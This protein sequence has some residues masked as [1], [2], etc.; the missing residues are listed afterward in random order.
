[1]QKVYFRLTCVTQ[2]Q[3]CSNSLQA[4]CSMTSF[5]YYYYQNPSGFCFLVQ[6][7]AFVIKTSMGLTNLNMEE[8]MK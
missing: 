5:Y 2:K 4:I 1:M 7:R 3:L 6:I 8:E